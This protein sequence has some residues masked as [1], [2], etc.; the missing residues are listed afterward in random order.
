MKLDLKVSFI[1]VT[2]CL[3]MSSLSSCS[4]SGMHNN[5]HVNNVNTSISPIM[6]R[7]ADTINAPLLQ[8]KEDKTKTP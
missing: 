7:S 5:N 2:G 4:T 3:V 6:I 8:N 1:L